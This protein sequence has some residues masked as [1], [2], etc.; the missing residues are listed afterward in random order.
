[1][2]GD[3]ALHLLRDGDDWLVAGTTWDELGPDPRRSPPPAGAVGAVLARAGT[4]PRRGRHVLAAEPLPLPVG[5]R[6]VGCWDPHLAR[7]DS[8]WLVAFVNAT[9]WF[10]FHPALAAGPSLDRLTLR[11]ADP[12]RTATEGVTLA[13]VPEADDPD[14][15]PCRLLVSDGPLAPPEQRERYVVLDLDLRPLGSLEAPYPTNIPW[16]TLAREGDRWWL[17]TFDGTPY[18]GRLP[19]Y[20]THGDLVVARSEGDRP[21]LG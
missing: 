19:G 4:D 7:D 12:T 18:G 13:R 8:G 5:P 6:S 10:R 14:P 16:P 20:G 3:H 2:H 21:G 9:A 17:V 11:A 15:G 1:M